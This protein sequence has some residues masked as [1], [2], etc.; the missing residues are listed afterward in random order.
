MA[1]SCECGG[2][3]VPGCRRRGFSDLQLLQD[4]AP[5][6]LD[7]LTRDLP[8]LCDHLQLLDGVTAIT[9]GHGAALA[10]TGR[11]AAPTTVGG[12]IA[13]PG[14]ALRHLPGAIATALRVAPRTSVHLNRPS[15]AT[16]DLFD[17]TGRRVHQ[18]RLTSPEDLRRLDSVGPPAA[19]GAPSAAA[20]PAAEPVLARPGRDDQI[21]LVDSHLTDRGGAR[22][23]TLMGHD[24]DDAHPVGSWLLEQV[25]AGVAELGLRPTFTVTSGVQQSHTGP[26][27]AIA[28]AGRTLRVRSGSAV[29]A[30]ST[31][32]VHRM[33]V[34]VAQGP[35]GPTTALELFDA[36]GN[37]LVLVTLTG[38][39]PVPAHRAW[40]ELLSLA[41]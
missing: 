40:H 34:S 12:A 19:H 29:L 11:Y 32:S 8:T 10:V 14:V 5:E 36:D 15:P 18:A 30:V 41:R 2:G 7:E 28:H 17:P 38:R 31:A 39:H 22:L 16:I 25:L 20:A 24:G 26:V 9:S 27:E 23:R 37:A 21:D 1:D 6:T 33:W 3:L 4:L 35:H 13:L